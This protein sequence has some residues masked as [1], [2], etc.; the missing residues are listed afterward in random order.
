MKLNKRNGW[1]GLQG[2]QLQGSVGVYDSERIKGNKL[3]LDIWVFGDLKLAI[4]SNELNNAFN[5]EVFE[6]IA[7]EE[8]EKGSVLLEP[9]ANRIL[10]RIIKELPKVKKA[11]IKVMKLSPPITSPCHAS[12]VKLKLSRKQLVNQA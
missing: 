3:Q 1:V 7:V 8:V 10:E 6:S 5:Y 12:V 4:T 11:K 9:L 2:L